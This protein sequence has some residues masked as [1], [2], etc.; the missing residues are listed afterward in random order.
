MA[1]RSR[2]RANSDP[3][4]Q[5]AVAFQRTCVRIGR[6]PT[7]NHI[8]EEEQ[9]NI[10]MR[11]VVVPTFYCLSRPIAEGLDEMAQAGVRLIEIHGDAPDNHID[12]TN[13]TEVDA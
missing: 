12:L 8:N 9:L 5:Y 2:L 3:A 11:D 10:Y 4:P 1:A 13:E 6:V 7:P